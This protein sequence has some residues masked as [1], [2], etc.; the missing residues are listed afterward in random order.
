MLHAL[1]H[2]P[3]SRYGLVLAMKTAPPVYTSHDVS[4]L[5]GRKLLRPRVILKA[6]LLSNEADV[7]LMW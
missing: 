5:D 3:D 7:L 2:F 4:F 1:G 6:Y